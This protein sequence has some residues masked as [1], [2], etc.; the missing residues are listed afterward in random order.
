[1][2]AKAVSTTIAFT[3]QHSACA[4]FWSKLSVPASTPASRVH[5]TRVAARSKERRSGP[6]SCKRL[7]PIQMALDG[8]TRGVSLP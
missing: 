1:M 6:M 2:E 4:Q 3:P 5:A 7:L 8:T